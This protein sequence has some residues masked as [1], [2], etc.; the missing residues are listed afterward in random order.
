MGKTSSKK[1]KF[2][3]PAKRSNWPIV[4][5]AAGL[6]IVLS[7]GGYLLLGKNTSGTSAKATASIGETVKYSPNEQLQQTKVPNS[8]Q[9][10][11]VTVATLSQVRQAKFT[12][13]EYKNNGKR[14]P[15]TAFAQPNGKLLVAVSLCEPCNSENF[16]ITG[17]KIICNACG[18]TWDLNTLKGLSGGCQQYP[19]DALSYTVNGDNIQV[20]QAV[21]DAWKP[22]V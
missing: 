5:A 8:I 21:L 3:A 2:V 15:V 16:H 7:V 19:P 6:I 10:G 20:D 14:V 13:T 11:K 9:N 18:T 1:E 12:W 17:D 4:L 22:R